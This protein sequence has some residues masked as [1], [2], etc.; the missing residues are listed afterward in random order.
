MANLPELKEAIIKMDG[1]AVFELT[2][3]AISED[4]SARDIL[5]E[6][7]I[8]GLQEVGELFGKGEYFLPELILAAD[9]AAEALKV[10]DP[11]LS[12]EGG[13]PKGR[14]LI[15]TVKGD[16]HDLGKNIVIMMLRG[17]GWD[18]TDLGVD[19][20]AED[21]CSA[22]EAGDYRVLGLSCLL[23]MTMPEAARTIEAL[24]SAGIKEKIKVMVGGAP[25]SP[26]WAES[27]GADAHAKDGPSAARIAATLV[28]NS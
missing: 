9:A 12:E 10:L 14:Y 13:P 8:P 22:V 15:G 27:I 7:L 16:V 24:E 5:D 1:D 17:N 25:T 3:R 2:N 19:V 28:G 4:V 20:S 23:T 11:I 6:G 26:E 21:F 18:V